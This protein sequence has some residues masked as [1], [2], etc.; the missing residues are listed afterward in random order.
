[1]AQV[2]QRL[3][4]KYKSLSSTTSTI[5]KKEEVVASC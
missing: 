1:M 2:V 3:P 5:K 4:D